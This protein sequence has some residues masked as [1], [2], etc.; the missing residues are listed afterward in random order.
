MNNHHDLYVFARKHKLLPAEAAVLPALF[1]RAA[2]AVDRAPEALASDALYF[3]HELGEYLA[4]V[5]RDVAEKVAKEAE[6]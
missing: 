4:S 1:E 5:A 2:K 3:N 6:A